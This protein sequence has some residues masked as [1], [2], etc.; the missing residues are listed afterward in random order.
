MNGPQV[1][2]HNTPY[3]IHSEPCIDILM[4]HLAQDIESIFQVLMSP[5]WQE[6]KVIK[7][8]P[9]E[10]SAFEYKI[11]ENAKK[12]E[13]SEAAVSLSYRL[14]IR[15]RIRSLLVA[16]LRLARGLPLGHNTSI[17]PHR[18]QVD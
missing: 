16:N 7:K 13:V 1:L 5:S 15:Q 3:C 8:V 14:I 10:L 11:K 2:P 17:L 12:E 9:S 4:M 18:A 6:H